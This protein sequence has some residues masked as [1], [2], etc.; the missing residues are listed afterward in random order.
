MTLIYAVMN[1]DLCCHEQCQAGQGVGGFLL[2]ASHRKLH[3]NEHR[4]PVLR[5]QCSKEFWCHDKSWYQ[6]K[7][8]FQAGTQLA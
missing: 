7:H 4:R 5:Y 3:L 2:L 6:L 8:G 1:I